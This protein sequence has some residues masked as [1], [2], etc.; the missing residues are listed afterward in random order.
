[1]NPKTATREKRLDRAND[2]KEEIDYSR[3]RDNEE[4]KEAFASIKASLKPKQQEVLYE[5]ARYPNGTTGKQIA[6]NIGVPYSQIS[7]RISELKFC[8]LLT[9]TGK[10]RD[11]CAI[12][13]LTKK[14]IKT[15]N[16]Y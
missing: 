11:K 15:H 2:T 10:R 3:G 5:F 13:K 9:K 4:S 7:G 8:D 14:G 1:M 12:I 16:A 6:E